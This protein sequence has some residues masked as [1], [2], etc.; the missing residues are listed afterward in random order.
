MK[1][2]NLQADMKNFNIYAANKRVWKYH[3]Q[4]L[5][6]LQREIDE[7]TIVVEDFNTP[8]S[9]IDKFSRWKINKGISSQIHMKYSPI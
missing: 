8:L 1:G 5:L 9:V 7:S 3:R 4:E 2:S 6:K